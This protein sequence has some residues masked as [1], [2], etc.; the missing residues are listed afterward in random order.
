MTEKVP[1]SR[2]HPVRKVFRSLAERGLTQSQIHDADLLGYLSGLLVD[3]V[4]TDNLYRL[5][6]EK[7]RTLEYLFEMMEAAQVANR[8]DKR[9][10]YKQIGDHALFMLGL[11]P[12]SLVRPRRQVSAKYYADAGRGSYKVVSD[13]SWHEPGTVVFR[14]L[15]DR[16]D[17]CVLS[18]NWV[19][20]YISDP[21]YQYMLRQFEII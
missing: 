9:V 6:D 1:I 3:F 16:F 10:V 19:R 7:G 13:I 8:S 2:D 14:K 5:R 11:F 21:F 4:S 12:E 20:E 17:R 18:L 15:A